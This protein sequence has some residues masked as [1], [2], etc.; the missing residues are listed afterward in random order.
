M[1][2]CEDEVVLGAVPLH[3]IF[4]VTSN[5][6]VRLA[7]F[8]CDISAAES[9]EQTHGEAL[10]YCNSPRSVRDKEAVVKVVGDGEDDTGG[11]EADY[12]E[13]DPVLQHLCFIISC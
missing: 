9:S 3:S 12:G 6:L 11:Q 10:A 13:H 2:G 1:R 4:L 7:S 5:E 8:R